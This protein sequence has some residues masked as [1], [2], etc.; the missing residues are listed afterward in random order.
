MNRK[1]HQLFL[2]LLLIAA[3]TMQLRAHPG[4]GESNGTSPLHFLLEPE[5][6]V[7]TLAALAAVVTI[8]LWRRRRSM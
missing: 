3:S 7:P 2:S 6:V 1:R 4:H 8:L 5:H